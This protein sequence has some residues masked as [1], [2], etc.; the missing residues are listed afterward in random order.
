MAQGT[1]KVLGGKPYKRY[2][3]PNV[4]NLP[5]QFGLYQWSMFY[6]NL[7]YIDDNGAVQPLSGVDDGTVIDLL[8]FL[9]DIPGIGQMKCY[10]T[11]ATNAH[12]LV[13]ITNEVS[14]PFLVTTSGGATVVTVDI[15]EVA[16]GYT[17]PSNAVFCTGF[18]CATV[19]DVV[20]SVSVDE[21]A[22]S[23]WANGAT[24]NA[25]VSQNKDSGST[26]VPQPTILYADQYGLDFLGAGN[27][28]FTD[29]AGK[30]WLIVGLHGKAQP[31]QQIEIG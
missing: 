19:A 3:D 1:Q 2:P 9:S 23:V 22:V 27:N 5:N 12:Q 24:M 21:M 18:P 31:S 28:T 13:D 20:G 6:A 29:T 25:P 16:V 15:G 7:T 8:L 14:V 30:K 11:G 10:H 26:L 4:S 17:G